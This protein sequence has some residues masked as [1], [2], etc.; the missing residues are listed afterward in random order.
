MNPF[1]PF[2]GVKGSGFGREVGR[3]GLDSY[4]E[5]KPIAVAN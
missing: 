1:A 3:E 4:R 2:G 5:T